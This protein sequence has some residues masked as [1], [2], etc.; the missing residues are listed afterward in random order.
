MKNFRLI[1]ALLLAFM[2]SCGPQ[3]DEYVQISGYAQGNSYTVKL[4]MK[5][6]SVPVETVRDSID[7]IILQIDTTLSGYNKKSILS[8]FNAG[9]KVPSTQMFL[10]MYRVAYRLFERSGGALDFGAAKLY[11]A[12][13]FGFRNSSFPTDEEIAELLA[14]SGMSHLPAEL[15]VT[16]GYV[17]PA[18]MGYPHLNFNAI[19]QGYS[20]DILARYLYSLGVKDMLI[21]IGEIWCDGLSPSGQP[22]SV[23]VDRPIDRPAG[24]ETETELS[25]VWSSEGKPAGIVTSG[26]YRKFYIRD[27][28][29]YAHTINPR[30]GYPVQHN[31][32][33][34]TVVSSSNAAESDAIATWC[35]VIGLHGAQVLILG[36]PNLEGYLVYTDDEGNMKEWVSPGFALKQ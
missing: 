31:L 27:G 18:A 33:S 36:D 22:W 2:I 28:R 1:G 19:A 7:A 4:N 12:W 10:D 14:Q 29:K 30:T 23:G 32:L 8:R 21:D 3:K 17:D 25:G 35:M 6:V 13:G 9:E 26:N 16:D 5:G 11:D 20:C 34:A 24:E 15:P